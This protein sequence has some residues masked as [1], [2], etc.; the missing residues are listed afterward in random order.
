CMIRSSAQ[1]SGRTDHTSASTALFEWRSNWLLPR[2]L[3][4]VQLFVG[5]MKE[6]FGPIS[7]LAFRRAVR[8]GHGKKIRAAWHLNRF[9]AA[10][11]GGE[12]R[13]IAIGEQKNKFIAAQTR[14]QIAFPNDFGKAIGKA[15]ENRVASKMTE[16]VIHLFKIVEIKKHKRQGIAAAAGAGHFC[17]EVALG[18]SAVVK[19]RQRI[20]QG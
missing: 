11:D 12:M 16:A 10:K 3:V 6:V 1:S 7:V 18:E 2:L 13:S 8:E 17:L 20:N 14:R 5:V 9:Q 15:F 19:T 4:F